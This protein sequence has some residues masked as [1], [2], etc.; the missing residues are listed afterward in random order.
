[1]KHKKK[2]V[3]IGL[4]GVNN[5]IA[6]FFGMGKSVYPFIS[7]IPPYTPPSWTSILTGVSPARHGIIGWQK[8]S[9]LN[10]KVGLT[11]SLDVKYPRLTEFLDKNN[12]SSILINLPMTYPF[13]GITHKKNTIIVSDWAA[14]RQAIF[15]RRLENLY[16]EYL[17]DPPHQWA[18]YDKSEYPK[19]VREYTESRMPLYY[20]LLERHDWDLYFIVFSET[21]WFLHMFPQL[22]EGKHISSVSSTFKLIRDFIEYAKSFADI[23]FIISDHGFQ[24]VTKTLY[25]NEILARAGFIRYDNFK[26]KLLSKVKKVFPEEFLLKLL[27]A[28]GKSSSIMSYT[29]SKA[30]AFM[31]EPATWGIYLHDKTQRDKVTQVLKQYSEILDVIPVRLLY[32]GPYIRTLPDLFVIPNKGVDFSHELK[33]TIFKNTYK[34]NHELRGM[35]F[36]HGDDINN[37]FITFEKLPRVYDIVPTIL[38]IFDL[39]IPVDIRGRVLKEIFNQNSEISKRPLKLMS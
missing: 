20:D 16:K 36:V 34:G 5:K 4:D 9:K 1:M 8:I 14:P 7:T 31:V 33:G 25:I 17:I 22:L 27:S 29:T 32:E 10:D 13:E 24:V 18:K 39:P 23:L 3:I 30:D 15:P 21:D 28:T 35:F 37:D 38:H 12:L 6:N 26:L 2:I 11:T 19:R